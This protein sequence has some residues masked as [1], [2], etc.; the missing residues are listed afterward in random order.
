[1]SLISR[2]P[3]NYCVLIAQLVDEPLHRV[4]DTGLGG[5][6][7]PVGRRQAHGQRLQKVLHVDLH[8]L[9]SLVVPS[10]IV[11]GGGGK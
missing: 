4:F 3:S 10:Q 5:L 1:M 7:V 6:D 11:Y 2:T 8:F 9:T